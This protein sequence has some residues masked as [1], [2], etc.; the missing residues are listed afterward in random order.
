MPWTE[1]CAMDERVRFVVEHGQDELSMTQ[2]CAK[3][4]ISRKTGYK[5]LRRAIESGLDHLQDRSRRPHHHPNQVAPAIEQA[6]LSLRAAHPSWGPKKLLRRL[7]D[8]DG[9]TR[10]PARSTLAEILRRHGLV[11]GRKRRRRAIPSQQPLSHCDGPNAVWCVDFK[12]WFRTG[13]G[14]RCDP[15]TLSD[16]FSRY[17]LRCQAVDTTTGLGVRP[18]LEAAFRQY[19]LP[20]AIRSDNGPPFASCSIAGLSQL[21][22]WWIKLGIVPERI[23]PGKPQQNGRHE[24]MH[25]TLKQETCQPPASTIRAQQR[26]FD[27]F[28]E[29]FNEQRPHEALGLDTPS[30]HYTASSRAYPGRLSEVVYPSDWSRRMVR[31]N[32]EVKFQGHLFFVSQ[33]LHGEP[34]GL[35]PL[36]GRYWRVHFSRVPLGIYDERRRR[37][38]RTMELKRSGLTVG[39]AAGKPPSATLQEASQQTEKV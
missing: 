2:L 28:V 8:G 26:R 14:R 4:G 18:V 13:D 33:T 20:R 34:V 6:I 25:L 27:R 31:H 3:Y 10:W 15:L 12:G 5:W 17:V 22:I 19:G 38:L 39:P 1:T 32:G 7:Q 23:E 9:R 16:G 30:A 29:V 35:E 11:T 36:D 24:R 21:S 37:L